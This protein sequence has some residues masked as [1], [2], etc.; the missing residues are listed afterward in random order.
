MIYDFIAPYI[1]K[2]ISFVA[3]KL[4]E[5]TGKFSRYFLKVYKMVEGKRE[6]KS[7]PEDSSEFLKNISG[8]K[9]RINK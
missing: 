3:K 5:V 6:T 4:Y 9:D 8:Y 1:K 2:G 7:N